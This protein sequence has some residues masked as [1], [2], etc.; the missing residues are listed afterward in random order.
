MEQEIGKKTFDADEVRR[1]HSV[2]KRDGELFEFRILCGGN[3]V[4][5]GYFTDVEKAI[6]LLPQYDQF[7]IYFT[8]NEVK[9]AC[10]SRKQFNKFI[11]VSGTATS[12]NDIEHRWWMPI[13]IDVERPSDVSST[14]EEKEYAHK[15][16][17]EVYTFLKNNAFPS[18][19]VCDSSSGYHMYY[20]IDLPN[21]TESENL[22]KSFYEV[23]SNFFTDEKVKI[24][25]VVGDANR[26]MRLEGT[27]GR[28]GRD[29]KERPHRMSKILSVP[30]D[31]V[32]MKAEQ[33][34]SFISK[35]KIVEDRPQH[36]NYNY[37]NKEEFDLR[38]F[39]SD[40]GI[41]V[42]KEASYGN[43][44]TKFVLKECPF[45]SSHKSP[46][47]AIFLTAQG[48]IGFKCL[49]NSCANHDWHELRLKFDPTAYDYENR[50]K[51][52]YRQPVPQVPQK[53]KYEIKDETPELG[54][55][56]LTFS[57]IQKIDLSKLEKIKTGYT[58]LDNSISGLF[59]FEVTILS[60]SNSSGKSSWLNS[61][62]LNII[63]Q[64]YK[65]ALWSGELRA[66]ILKTWIQL[67]AAGKR[68]VRPS[69]YEQGRYY[70]PDVIGNKIDHWLDGKFFLYNNE[71]GAKIEQI[72]N[73]ME[74]LVKLGVKVFALD[75]L[76]SLDVD[77]FEGDKNTKQKALILRIKA[78]AMEH[79]VHIILVAHPRKVTSFLRK[80]DI[81]GSSDL[82]NA[83]DNVFIIHRV[84]NDF[85][86]AGDEYFGK[87]KISQFAEYGNV[88][89]VCKNR[90]YGAVDLMV[91]MHYEMESRRFKNTP[92]EDIHYGWE[93]EPKQQSLTFE[94][95]S[96]NDMPF[97][98]PD[99]TEA[100]F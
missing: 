96:Y 99:G 61:L 5:S 89:E 32:R 12:K 3:K 47:S 22:V 25:K 91:G 76:M 38:K 55:K 43:G 54:E 94:S 8:V 33:I 93:Q 27:W 45:D 37:G 11:F 71:Y 6:S 29:T 42:A 95:Q 77:L 87:G 62:L 53:P 80:T 66:D 17:G 92:D 85:T 36:K 75:N 19:V 67:V 44:G 52:Q 58:Q 15:K 60:G 65:I 84:N 39:M 51:T 59:L 56:W 68:N 82:S 88:L 9:S 18:P 78:F 70:V 98:A 86:R 7:Q 49:H 23:L 46:D 26:I 4:Y 100:P 16:A 81:S 41:E 90:I 79:Q 63:Q 13:D 57:S 14:D 20:P 31:I 35:Y 69:Q 72:I 83:V 48:A 21:T 1:W 64:G 28:K 24:D 73:D 40:N 10:S 34:S 30:T 50:P 74:I 97:E 2:F